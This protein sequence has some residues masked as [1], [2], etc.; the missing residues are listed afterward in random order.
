[1]CDKCVLVCDTLIKYSVCLSVYNTMN[2]IVL[3]YLYRK[4]KPL[5]DK[6]LFSVAEHPFIYDTSNFV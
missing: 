3:G 6:M 5:M 4:K 2:S 1:M